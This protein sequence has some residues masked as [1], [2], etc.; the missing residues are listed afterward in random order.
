MA[1][2]LLNS[3]ELRN[4]HAIGEDGVLVWQRADAFRTS[5]QNSKML[6]EKYSRCLATPRFTADGSHVDWFIPFE[7]DRPDGEY[8]VVQWSA[9]SPQEQADARAKLENI[10]EKFINFGYNL[11]ANAINSNDRLF[12]HFL[13][14]NE[15]SKVR[16][17]A[18]HFPDISCVYIVNGEPVITFWGFLKADGK[19]QGG[20]FDSLY[21]RPLNDST[22][23]KTADTTASSAAAAATGAAVGAAHSHRWCCF[24]LPLLALLLLL[25]LL[26]LLWWYFFAKGKPLFKVFPNLNLE[27]ELALD[28]PLPDLSLDGVD[29][30]L[31]GEPLFKKDNEAL[32]APLTD[33]T[34]ILDD[35][36]KTP[37][38]PIE[39]PVLA[40]EL[41]ES[42]PD[43]T[44]L[45]NPNEDIGKT[46]EAQKPIDNSKPGEVPLAELENPDAVPQKAVDSINQPQG[47]AADSTS[48][49]T[50]ISN[51]DLQSGDIS[52]FDGTWKVESMIVDK[53]TNKPLQLQY[54][55]KNGKGTA[56]ITQKNG[57]KCQGAV[58][59]GLSNGSFKIGSESTAR[60]TDGT[61]YAL[62]SVVC[63]PGK[64]GY[65][66]CTSSYSNKSEPG[67]NY[68]F[69]MTIHR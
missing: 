38:E 7:S 25:L 69:P 49:E 68:N 26:Y 1:S 63:V 64:N 14:G 40:D 51:A 67:K 28:M 4:Y 58:D 13:T 56:T 52:K 15:H 33:D 57:V 53:Q 45:E 47:V 19:L 61:T 44:S 32:N 43:N 20:P 12:S 18:F 62:P 39:E 46:D 48:A 34:V 11:Q 42:L 2:K 22:A 31:D 29:L 55:F 8:H 36:E 59:G 5:I 65:S 37:L 24:L 17:P 3:G 41:N 21:L 35:E 50:A 9:A 30:T 16:L 6:G 54:D 27:P 60:C 10:E 23:R 66:Q